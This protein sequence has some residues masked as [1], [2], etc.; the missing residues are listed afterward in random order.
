MGN[1]SSTV[2]W[3]ADEPGIPIRTDAKVSDVGTTATMPIISA[4]PRTGS[5]PNMKGS[6]SERPAI[7]PS[8]G[9]TPMARPITTPRTR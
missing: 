7:P 6:S 3:E 9:K 5:M 1:P 8:P 2:A 4:R